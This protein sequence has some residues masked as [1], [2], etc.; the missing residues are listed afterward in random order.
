[1]QALK[2]KNR[3]EQ[4]SV[5]RGQERAL[6]GDKIMNYWVNIHHPKALNES[7]RSQCRVYVQKRSRKLPSAGDEVFIYETGALSGE[8]VI[9]EDENGR[10]KVKLGQG[11]KGLIALVEIVGNLRRHEW[12]WN[13]TPYIGS[14]NTR[15]IETRR[16]VVKLDEINASYSNL[17]IP[18]SF[19]PRTYT[20]LRILGTDEIK[21]LLR[22]TGVR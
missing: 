8:T 22:L 14:Y 17:G 11:A 3:T 6:K 16:K 21:T 10:H 19:N 20:G 2:V 9:S 18:H 4:A 7:R 12:I 5:K 15:E 13:G 1:M